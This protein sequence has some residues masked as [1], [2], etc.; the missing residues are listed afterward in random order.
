MGHHSARMSDYN[1]Q[2]LRNEQIYEK[3]FLL[4]RHSFVLAI[5][6]ELPRLLD[7][8]TLLLPCAQ[9]FSVWDAL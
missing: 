8:V 9:S 7:D 1:A 2:T 3:T 5:F 6:M 4:A